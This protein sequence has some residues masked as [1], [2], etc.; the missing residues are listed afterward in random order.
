MIRKVNNLV[1]KSVVII[2]DDGAV[3]FVKRASKYAY[4]KKFPDKKQQVYK[5]ILF[6]NGCTLPHPER[7]RVAHQ[8]EQLMSQGLTVESVF[9]DRLSLDQLKYYR[10][11][12]FFRCP[13]TDTIRE[14]IKQA[15]YF[16]KTCF[17]DIDDLVIDQ[18]YT[19]SIK[20]VQRMSADDKRLYDD[21]VNRMRE[22]LELCD[23]VVTT[24]A[25]LQEE[26][27]HY[28][29]GSVLINRNVASDEMIK[30]SN[31]A[32]E[33]VSKDN[34]KIIIGYF[35]GSITHNEDFDLVI[36]SL[37]KIFEKY[38][39]IYLKIA[40]FWMF[41]TPLIRIKSVLLRQDLLIGENCQVLW[42]S[43]ILFWRR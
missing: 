28:T 15:H 12:V 36:P 24:T 34:N 18:K 41:Q 21:G 37:I 33:A 5:D 39:Q 25:Q 2:K 40:A 10:G 30:L 31:L 9:Y 19:D 14:F 4:Y 7:Y 20:Y 43:A 22:T 16:N 23:H 29:K 1:K 42:Q 27:Q 32:L 3:R 35:S 11:F 13:I 38:P 8:M 26:L 17:F 6:I